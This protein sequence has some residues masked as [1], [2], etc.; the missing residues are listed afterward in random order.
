MVNT[1]QKMRGIDIAAFMLN[2]S[3]DLAKDKNDERYY[4]DYIKLHKLLFLGQCYLLYKYGEH[5]FYE[6]V[7]AND[8]GPYID[9]LTNIVPG[10]C[11]FGPIT[12]KIAP[13]EFRCD[14]IAPTVYQLEAIDEMLSL[15]GPHSTFAVV[16]MTKALNA[17]K[18]S[19]AQP[20]NSTFDG[21]PI[22]P[23]YMLMVTG[24]ELFSN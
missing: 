19:I 13:R 21:R 6:D 8:D 14:T 3:I 7:I 12:R 1:M 16:T 2:R 5:L 4:M 11:G 17:Y 23:E 22:I 20:Q 15:Y 24:I 18:E 9:S 10:V